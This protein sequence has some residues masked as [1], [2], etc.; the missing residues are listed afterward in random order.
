MAQKIC[1]TLKDWIDGGSFY[2]TQHVE[3]LPTD[4]VFNPMRQ[5][6]ETAFVESIVHE[7]VTINENEEIDQ[8]AQRLVSHS[9][10][11]VVVVDDSGKLGGIVTSWDITKSIANGKKNLKDIIVR[12][13]YTTSLNEPLEV[14]SRTLAQHN[15][16]ALPVV[17]GSNRVLGIVTSEDISRLLGGV[18]AG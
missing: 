6:S 3:K 10:N 2:L 12:K 1:E 16:S 17:D 9:V 7:A 4:T 18:G 11:H 15:I 5:T 13:V 14:A 8:V